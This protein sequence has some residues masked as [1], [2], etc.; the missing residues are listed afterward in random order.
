[1]VSLMQRRRAM[2]IQ[3]GAS[4]SG[5]LYQLVQGTYTP[6][7]G[8]TTTITGNHLEELY[9]GGAFDS[10]RKYYA[11]DVTILSN[12]PI[13]TTWFSLHAGD[14][15]DLKMKNI[16][17]RNDYSGASTTY[18]VNIMDTSNTSILSASVTVP[19]KQTI[20]PADVVKS[21]TLASD[22]DVACLYLWLNRKSY[23]ICDL[24]LWVNGIQYI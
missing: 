13:T 3:S 23:M 18:S 4:P 19:N 17:F 20:T 21:V 8:R 14:V 11:N 10:T 9:T 24:E 6:D 16:W 1:M 22:I 5:P 15:V 2:M 7:S 12:T